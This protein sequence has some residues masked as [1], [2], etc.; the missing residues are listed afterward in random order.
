MIETGTW[1]MATGNWLVI[2]AVLA[3]VG[4]RWKRRGVGAGVVIVLSAG[5][6]C[7]DDYP[8]AANA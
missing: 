3:A 7:W 8:S 1:K 5:W 4:G 6:W 2:L